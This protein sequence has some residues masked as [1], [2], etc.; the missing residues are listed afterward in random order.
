MRKSLS[1][2]RLL[3]I[4][5]GANDS[6]K[7]SN[8]FN[9]PMEH[10]R[11]PQGIIDD[12][13][14]AQRQFVW[15]EQE[16]SKRWHAVSWSK[17]CEPKET[18][19]MD[20][21]SLNLMNDAF[22][23]KMLWRM[24][25]NPNEIWVQVRFGKYHRRQEGESD[26]CAKTGDFR[27]WKE[28]VK[29]EKVFRE[30]TIMKMKNGSETRVWLDNWVKEDGRLSRFLCTLK[31]NELV[32]MDGYRVSDQI[33]QLV[34]HD[35]L[36]KIYDMPQSLEVADAD[37]CLWKPEGK[38]RFSTASTYK[39]LFAAR[40]DDNAR[41]WRKIWKL[42]VPERVRV[43]MWHVMHRRLLTRNIKSK[44]D[45]E[46]SQCKICHRA[47]EE[48]LHA[49]RDCHYASIFWRK[50]LKIERV[51]F[52]GE[53]WKEWLANNLLFKSTGEEDLFSPEHFAIGCWKLWS[54]RNQQLHNPKFAVPWKAAEIVKN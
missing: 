49:Q 9:Y 30:N 33:T 2:W 51:D 39:W 48:I 3:D 42:K 44:W 1:G 43:F 19:G 50:L 26:M 11:L 17:V 37:E 8:E 32:S 47:P 31:V 22:I 46:D 38:G 13:E 40:E 20:I 35:I 52:M 18:G 21:K 45:W 16:G 27:L 23:M 34:P 7:I 14:R 24:Y 12:L 15:G 54:R 6:I 36:R 10:D 28:L 4:L 53:K 41:V 25:K 29:M 5:G